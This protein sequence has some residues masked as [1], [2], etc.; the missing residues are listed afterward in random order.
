MK[1]IT[2]NWGLRITAIPILC[3]EGM[4]DLGLYQGNVNGATF[5]DFVDEKLCPNLLP[6]NGINSRSVLIM[7]TRESL[8]ILGF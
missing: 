2:Q 8:A 5:K 4:I 1:R 6:F 7:G 3:T